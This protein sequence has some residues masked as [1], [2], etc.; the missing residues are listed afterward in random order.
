MKV[1][2]LIPARGGSKGVPR[3]NIREING[4]PLIEYSINVAKKSKFISEIIVSSDCRDILDFAK[5]KSCITH[6]RSKINSSDSAKIGDVI[7]E[8]LDCFNLNFDLILLLQPTAPIREV[9]DLDNIIKKFISNSNLNTVVS[10]VELEDI[11]PARMYEIEEASNTL[12]SLNPELQYELRQ[13]LPKVYLRNGSIYAFKV[14]YFL[15]NNKPYDDNTQPYIM[16]ESKWAN[17]DTERDFDITEFM[18]KKFYKK[19]Q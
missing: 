5:S 17:I 2:G 6:S 13:N 12:K 11:H 16:D 10:V 14:D 1:L 4:K 7:N 18:L 19:Y 15:A 9:D 8:V 3:K